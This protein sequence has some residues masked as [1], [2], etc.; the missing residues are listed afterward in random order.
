MK[1]IPLEEVQNI[2]QQMDWTPLSISQAKDDINSMRTIDP[3]ATIDK[4]IEEESKDNQEY[5]VYTL[6]ELKSRILLAQ[7]EYPW[8]LVTPSGVIN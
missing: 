8:R 7:K 1:L 4:M 5:T 2:F 3:I 6:E